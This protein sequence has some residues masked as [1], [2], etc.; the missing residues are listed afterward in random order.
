MYRRGFVIGRLSCEVYDGDNIVF[1]IEYP[2]VL[3]IYLF[4]WRFVTVVQN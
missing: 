1:R 3:D 2:C 4:K